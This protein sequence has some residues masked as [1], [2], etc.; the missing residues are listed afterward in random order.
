MKKKL[1][2][3]SFNS[4]ITHKSMNFLNL[5]FSVKTFAEK[6]AGIFVMIYLYKNGLLVYQLFLVFAAIL[7]M[8]F[9]LRPL[10]LKFTLKNGLKTSL[11]IGIISYAGLFQVL[12]F[13]KGVNAWLFFYIFYEAICGVF[14]WLPF[15]A[16]F[17]SLGQDENCGKHTGVREALVSLGSTISP[18]LGAFLIVKYN[19]YVLFAAASILVLASLIPIFR[20]SDV[21]YGGH[22][23]FK[24][25]YRKISKRGFWLFVGD[26]WYTV[27]MQLIWPLIVYL[28][29]NSYITYGW[30]FTIALL[31]Q[32]I[33]YLV[34]GSLIDEGHERVIYKAA[35]LFAA[36]L[37]IG[38]ALFAYEIKTVILFSFIAAIVNCFYF[39]SLAIV[40]YNSSRKSK[41][42]LW[43]QFF[44]ESGWDIGAFAMAVITAT[45]V[46]F[47]IGLRAAFVVAVAGLVIVGGVSR[48][49]YGGYEH[50]KNY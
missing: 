5:H 16:Y 14:Y 29:F 19:F 23:N 17:A 43:F 33:G 27:G 26:G 45:L 46:Y 11:I 13:V 20:I 7:I 24:E 1:P 39:P 4:F 30:I 42:T 3:I 35:L 22:L 6:L 12:Y 8:R 18:A 47:D 25:A 48:K 36:F 34:L 9:M 32:S 37:I 21:P 2:K 50:H 15:H 28:L 40:L 38:Q 10:S 41:N 31:S 44:A 49:Y